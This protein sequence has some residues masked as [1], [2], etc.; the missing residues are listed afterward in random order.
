MIQNL[1][2]TKPLFI[3]PFDH[4]GTFEKAGFKDISKQKQIIYEAFKK[5]LDTVK[6]AAILVD[7][8]YGDVILKDAKENGY[9]V[10]LT[11]EKSGQEDF[12]F[13]YGEDF[14]SHIE[15]YNPDFAKVLIKVSARGGSAYGGE[16]GVSD[17]TK[18]NLKKLNDYCRF[19]SLKLLIEIV[20]EGNLDLILKT[21]SELQHAGI[22]PDV[23]KVEGMENEFAYEQIVQEARRNGRDNVS[24]VI[25]GRGEG[26]EV[27]EKWIK[28]GSKTRG[29][30]GF[31]IGRT[32]FWE[33]LME[34]KD[35]KITREEAVSKISENYIYFY[36]LFNE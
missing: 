20:S 14:K 26:K 10:L 13:E 27:V 5:S 34:F 25:L 35:G 9:T 15:K 7:E 19:A 8:E 1:G 6:N 32:I 18:N 36:N 22:D 4:R 17:L 30:I 28:T 11:I 33:P 3:L 24:V 23:W 12:I 31:A 16:N 2:Y 29:V 21:I